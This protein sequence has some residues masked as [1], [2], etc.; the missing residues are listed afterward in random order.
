VCDNYGGDGPEIISDLIY[1]TLNFLFIFLIKSAGRLVKKQ[2]LRLLD[3]SSGD[4]Y[5]LL[6]SSRKLPAR[7]AH[8]RVD[9]LLS[10]FLVN[11]IPG[12]CRFQRLNDL[13][14]CRVWVAVE[15]VLLDRL[16]EEDGLLADIPNLPS[17]FSKAKALNISV[18]DGYIAALWVVES[19]DKLDDGALA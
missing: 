9:A 14:V 8:V 1:C 17:K 12:V 5:P 11:K 4:S 6:L 13:L 15:E 16:V 18:I 10:H 3:E 7:I 2:N 19:F